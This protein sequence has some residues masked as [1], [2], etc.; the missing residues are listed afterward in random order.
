M[1]QADFSTIV[2]AIA[3]RRPLKRERKVVRVVFFLC[4]DFS[5]VQSAFQGWQPL[6]CNSFTCTHVHPHV[7]PQVKHLQSHVPPEAELMITIQRVSN[8]PCRRVGE[9]AKP[10]GLSAAIAAAAEAAA[11]SDAA[12]SPSRQAGECQLVPSVL[13]LEFQKRGMQ[14]RKQHTLLPCRAS[15]GRCSRPT[16]KGEVAAAATGRPTWR[17][18]GRPER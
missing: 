12:L 3:P 5:S 9:L 18:G 2:R 11:L 8:L 1:A 14:H 4:A 7:S 16:E 13:S 10:G 6:R 15:G 17:Q